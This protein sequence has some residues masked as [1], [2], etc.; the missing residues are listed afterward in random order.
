MATYN[1]ERYIQEQLDSLFKQTYNNVEIYVRD[2]GSKDN[3]VDIIKRNL[4]EHENLHLYD[5][6]NHLGYPSCFYELVKKKIDGDFFSLLIR[7]I[8]G[9]KT[10]LKKQ[11]LK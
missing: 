9:W 7:M 3:T 2:D 8:I 1:G 4:L 10:K 11:L 6:K 5:D